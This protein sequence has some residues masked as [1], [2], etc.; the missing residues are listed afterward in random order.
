MN[1]QKRMT[2]NEIRTHAHTIIGKEKLV[3]FMFTA[4]SDVQH[5]FN[6]PN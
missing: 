6:L 2:I 3:I 4:V 5:E 1:R